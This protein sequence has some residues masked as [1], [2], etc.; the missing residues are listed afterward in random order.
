M[1]KRCFDLDDHEWRR[2]KEFL[3]AI[4]QDCDVWVNPASQLVTDLFEREFRS[5]L[6][7]QHAL[8]QTPLFQESFDAAF[9]GAA[10]CAGHKVRSADAGQRFW[11]IELDGRR[12][13][14]KSSK[15][16]NLSVNTLSISKLTEAAWIQECRSAAVRRKH[17]ISLFEEYVGTVGAI[18]QLRYFPLKCKYE[19]V[20]V[21][22][23]LFRGVFD[24]GREHFESDGPT[25]NIPIGKEPPDFTLKL[26]R[27][28]AKV[29][30]TKINKSLCAVHAT[31]A[32]PEAQ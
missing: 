15:A 16:R 7:T 10:K 30:I 19:L 17:T 18:I 28:D 3:S 5:R 13:S 20:E 31:W 24:V 29:T 21:P 11:D 14:L 23:A 2:V 8:L 27:S 26:D 9:L 32:L 6:L 4:R 1:A 25:I 22:V 12:I